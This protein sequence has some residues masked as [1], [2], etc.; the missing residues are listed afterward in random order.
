MKVPDSDDLFL[1]HNDG[2]ISEAPAGWVI[3]P[4]MMTDLST[5]LAHAKGEVACGPP[6]AGWCILPSHTPTIM[7]CELLEEAAAE[8]EDAAADGA[9][10]SDSL[11]AN[12]RWLPHHPGQPWH[13]PP[14][15]LLS[16]DPALKGKA[17]GKGKDKGSSTKGGAT[18]DEGKGKSKVKG[19]DKG[20]G[21]QHRKGNYG[22]SGHANQPPPVVHR[23]GW[24]N[25]CQQLAEAVLAESWDDA[26]LMAAEMYSGPNE[27]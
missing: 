15:N 21:W 20:K 19:K 8:V 5:L 16:G 11:L 3:S 12:A 10:E 9:V 22:K 23:G 4:N 24:F 26:Q 1:W 17:K 13:P 7:A 18:S 2:E 6:F 25:K 27:Y 14:A